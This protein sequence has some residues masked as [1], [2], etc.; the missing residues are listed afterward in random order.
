ML[1][2]HM[3]VCVCV[4]DMKEIESV[5]SIDSTDSARLSVSDSDVSFT[6]VCLCQLCFMM[7]H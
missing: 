4:V 7:S 6:E 1:Y 5:E 3:Y 2:I